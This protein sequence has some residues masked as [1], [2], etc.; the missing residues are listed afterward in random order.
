MNKIGSFISGSIDEVKNKVTWPTF[1]ELQTNTM[2][3]LVASLIFALVIGV[4]DFASKY[5]MEVV[6]NISA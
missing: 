3:V 5:L 2:L 4:I 1:S 6:Y